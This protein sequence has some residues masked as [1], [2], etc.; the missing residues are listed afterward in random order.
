MLV[1]LS[2]CLII[3]ETSSE[4][5]AILSGRNVHTRACMYAD[6]MPSLVILPAYNLCDLLLSFPHTMYS[7]FPLLPLQTK[8]F[9]KGT[10]NTDNQRAAVWR[11][12]ADYCLGKPQKHGLP[13][14]Q[15][16]AHMAPARAAA[17]HKPRATNKSTP[18]AAAASVTTH[19]Q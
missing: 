13:V 14:V 15:D 12:H 2:S 9:G 5:R 10:E 8:G 18:A 7:L 17:A 19:A 3:L 1:T 4:F 6:F 16:D 11:G